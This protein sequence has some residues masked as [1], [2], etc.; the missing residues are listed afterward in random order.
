MTSE[1]APQ[2]PPPAEE[3]NRILDLFP[4]EKHGAIRKA[5]ANNLKAIVAQ[6]PSLATVVEYRQ[7]SSTP[8]TRRLS[9]T[10]RARAG[11]GNCGCAPPV[12]ASGSRAVSPGARPLPGSRA[13]R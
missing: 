10:S 1:P 6:R 7:P 12:A 3:R 2:A 11:G 8:V 4:P 13:A 5:L 9:S